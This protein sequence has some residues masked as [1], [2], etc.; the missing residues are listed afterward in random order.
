MLA[1]QCRFVL[2]VTRPVTSHQE[3]REIMMFSPFLGFFPFYSFQF[4]SFPNFK[5]CFRQKMWSVRP[6]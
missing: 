2:G 6:P 1:R 5:L 3:K 4:S